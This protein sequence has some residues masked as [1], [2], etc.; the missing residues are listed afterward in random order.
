M[1][2]KPPG[3]EMA[4]SQTGTDCG[5]HG[6]FPVGAFDRP[7]SRSRGKARKG[8]RGKSEQGFSVAILKGENLMLKVPQRVGTPENTSRSQLA[9]GW[10]V[11]W[12]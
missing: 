1:S 5:T 9:P 6:S 11:V 12:K 8:S 4:R 2:P 10:D 3:P 7:L